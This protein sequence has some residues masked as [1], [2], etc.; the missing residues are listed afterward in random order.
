[1]Q[2]STHPNTQPSSAKKAE[3]VVPANDAEDPELSIVVPALNEAVTI[4][5]F[6]DWCKKGIE[7]AGI[8]A[9]IL[10]VDSSTDRTADVAVESGARVL[11]TPQRGLG[12][13]YMDALPF[14]RGKYILM[15]DADCTYDFRELGPFVE[16]FREG[17]EFIMGSRFKGTIEDGSMPI[18]HRY[19]GTPVTTWVLNRI[20]ASKFSDIHCGMRGITT[21]A[22]RRMR[23]RSESWEYAS[24]MVLR[25]VRMRLKTAEVPVRFLR[26]QPGRVSH[27][28]RS[29]WTSPWKAAW[30]SLRAMF[31]YG[32][33]FFVYRPGIVLASLGLLLTL[34]LTFGP[35]AV[36]P[37]TFSLYWMLIGMTL[38]LVGLQSFYAGCLAQMLYDETGSSRERWLRV[39]RYN[40]TLAISATIFLAGLVLSS[41]LVAKYIR[42]GLTLDGIGATEHMAITG[43]MLMIASFTTFV[44]VLLFQALALRLANDAVDAETHRDS[45]P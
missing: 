27:H 36:G 41:F 26:D 19:L 13:A 31:V 38:T 28:K 29:G 11:T 9:E 18:L 3:L 37:V 45:G 40:R 23:I 1:M 10:I 34:P 5:D 15:G 4:G 22:F 30:A 21:D 6:V 17:Y 44:F 32:A 16:R 25:S 8:S 33:D 2:A 24:E 20:Y 43:L 39:F 12:R 7:R 42:L 35:I 14:V